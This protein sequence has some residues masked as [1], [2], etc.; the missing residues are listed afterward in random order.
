MPFWNATPAYGRT[1][2]RSK[3][4][5]EAKETIPLI[6]I[7]N[8]VQKKKLELSVSI[9]LRNKTYGIGGQMVAQGLICRESVYDLTE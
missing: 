6:Y 3:A 5:V 1:Q 4:P 7:V 8:C 9:T 2:S